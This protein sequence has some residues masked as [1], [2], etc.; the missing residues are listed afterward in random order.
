M[1]WL[2]P[3]SKISAISVSQIGRLQEGYA[4]D[5]PDSR[6]TAAFLPLYPL[7]MRWLGDAL[8]LDYFTA[9][10][11][12][13]RLSLLCVLWMFLAYRVDEASP[14]ADAWPAMAALL[15]FPSSFILVAA[16]SD[17]LFLA[18]A[19]ATFALAKRGSPFA[20]LTAFLASL[21]RVHGLALIPAL[22]VVGIGQWRAGRRSAAVF[23]PAV[24]CV[25]AYGLLLALSAARFGDPLQHFVVRH[26][27]WKQQFTMPWTTVDGAIGNALAALDRGGFGA[28]Y[29]LLEIPCLYLLLAAIAILAAN[30]P[31]RPWPEIVFL[32]GIVGL[33]IF[34]GTLA[35]FPR[36]TLAAFPVFMLLGK[37]RRWPALWYGYLLAGA[38]LQAC[39]IVHYVNFWP[40]AP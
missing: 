2:Y 34:C 36:Y 38:M 12:I 7:A 9:G 19:L 35:A 40:P 37:L 39:L 31:P 16:Y 27:V 29:T 23:V 5:S 11:W 22:A 25:A 17:A 6:D 4:G 26:E 21:T 28:I 8:G 33:S 10:L 3:K 13:S 32:A 24:A 30:P 1:P 15:A 20:S 14:P 18:L